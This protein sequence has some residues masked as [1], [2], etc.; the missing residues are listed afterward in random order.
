[1]LVQKKVNCGLISTF[2]FVPAYFYFLKRKSFSI[3]QF[4]PKIPRCCKP[5]HQHSS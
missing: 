4:L 2:P 1:M 5:T 3:K